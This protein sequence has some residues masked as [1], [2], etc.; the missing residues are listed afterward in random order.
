MHE[1]GSNLRKNRR[2]D[3]VGGGT[4]KR[5]AEHACE[6]ES[7]ERLVC[8]RAL[9]PWDKCGPLAYRDDKKTRKVSQ[10]RGGSL[11]TFSC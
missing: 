3:D 6:R 11:W 10:C 8:M 2:S 7:K 5:A 9:W 4:H 1:A